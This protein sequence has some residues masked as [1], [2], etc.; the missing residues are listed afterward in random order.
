MLMQI[1][2]LGV[3][4]ASPTDV[5][6]LQAVQVIAVQGMGAKPSPRMDLLKALLGGSSSIVK[7]IGHAG[8][9]PSRESRVLPTV[10]D[11]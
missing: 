10:S 8:T 5:M 7:E 2:G 11:P 6:R 1:G 4:A 9:V 3:P